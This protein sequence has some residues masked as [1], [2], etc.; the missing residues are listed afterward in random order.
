MYKDE[1]PRRESF[2]SMIKNNICPRF[3]WKSFTFA[4]VVINL[5]FFV[6]V[7]VYGGFEPNS[8][9]FLQAKKEVLIL[10]GENSPYFIRFHFEIFRLFQ[11]LF[12]SSASFY[13][14]YNN[15]FLI[16]IGSNFEAMTSWKTTAVVYFVSGL[17]AEVLSNLFS[18]FP[19]EG[20]LG[21]IM[22]LLGGFI[23]KVFY[24]GLTTEALR[25]RREI[26]VLI[27]LCLLTLLMILL[28]V[29]I[30]EGMTLIGGF[31]FGIMLGFSLIIPG[32][33][34]ARFRKYTKVFCG[35]LAVLI[36]NSALIIFYLFRRPVFY[37]SSDGL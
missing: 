18:D 26:V 32:N 35:G 21:G 16:I 9:S 37:E 11:S 28:M 17:G 36:I 30:Y 23:S 22:G 20:N 15:I 19:T 7:L 31:L 34:E 6:A 1:D 2:T 14:L 5:I 29:P 12:L 3:T 27:V 24:V 10:F 13:F 8:M 4:I 25:A 33:E